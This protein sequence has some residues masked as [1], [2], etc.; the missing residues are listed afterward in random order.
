[1]SIGSGTN[2]LML[3]SGRVVLPMFYDPKDVELRRQI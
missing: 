3:P 1:M 2:G